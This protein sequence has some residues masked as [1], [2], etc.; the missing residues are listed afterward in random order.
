MPQE[1]VRR[2]KHDSPWRQT[3]LL[4][5]S[6]CSLPSPVTAFPDGC[7]RT[8]FRNLSSPVTAL[9][10]ALLGQAS[11]A[12]HHVSRRFSN[13][14]CRHFRACLLDR[15][16]TRKRPLRK[17]P[18]TMTSRVL[19]A[20]LVTYRRDVKFN[21]IVVDKLDIN[22]QIRYYIY[23]YVNI[24][25]TERASTKMYGTTFKDFDI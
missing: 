24:S 4:S 3:K 13:V 17:R 5:I 16:S 7:S 11:V 14:I 23:V 1:D 15:K 10:N 12:F 2:N 9:R 6:F 20:T 18:L 19:I 21:A 25:E 8:S 22:S